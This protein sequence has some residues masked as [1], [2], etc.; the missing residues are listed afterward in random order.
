MSGDKHSPEPW[1][2]EQGSMR[3][4]ET[5][6][7]TTV[8]WGHDDYSEPTMSEANARR[9]VAC[10]NACAGMSTEALEGDALDRLVH[11][12]IEAEAYL[13]NARS[14]Y[15]LNLAHRLFD[16]LRFLGRLP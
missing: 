3:D 2:V 7:G 12:A 5:A 9:I 16:H 4:I 10:V 14:E 8:V 13:A 1:R 11:L 6:T 15:P